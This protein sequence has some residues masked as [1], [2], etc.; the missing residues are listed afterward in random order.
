MSDLVLRYRQSL[1]DQQR[2]ENADFLSSPDPHEDVQSESSEA[3]DTVTPPPSPTLGGKLRSVGGAAL[4]ATKES[5]QSAY[6]HFTKGVTD[7]WKAA[8]QEGIM[9]RAAGIASGQGEMVLGGLTM[10]MTGLGIPAVAAAFEKGMK[11]FTPG[12]SNAEF[13]GPDEATLVRVTLGLPS[14]I[15]DPELRKLVF[16]DRAKLSEEDAAKYDAVWAEIQKPMTYAEG[17]GIG[18]AF[19]LLPTALSGLKQYMNRARIAPEPIPMTFTMKGISEGARVLAREEAFTKTQGPARPF[20]GE[21]P[22]TDPLRVQ[23]AA[24]S[25]TPTATALDLGIIAEDMALYLE[26]VKGGVKGEGKGKGGKKSAVAAPV[27]AKEPAKAPVET[28]AAEKPTTTKPYEEP[29]SPPEYEDFITRL[30][31]AFEEGLK[32]AETVIKKDAATKPELQHLVVSTEKAAVGRKVDKRVGKKVSNDP[33]TPAETERLTSYGM[34][35]EDLSTM[36]PAAAR[37]ILISNKMS[38]RGLVAEVEAEVQRQ[39]SLGEQG[40]ADIGLLARLAVGAAVGCAQGDD[41]EDCLTYGL[42]GMVGAVAAGRLASSLSAKFKTSERMRTLLNSKTKMPGF[43]SPSTVSHT[44]E[45]LNSISKENKDTITKL[46]TRDDTT[47]FAP[48]ELR[49]GKDV[50]MVM[51]ERVSEMLTDITDKNF[52]SRPGELRVALATARTL[53]NK[54]VLGRLWGGATG[55][56]GS[57]RVK[58]ALDEINKLAKEWDASTSE[59]EMAR[60]LKAAGSIKDMSVMARLYYAVPE[61]LTQAYIGGLL[62]PKAIIRNIVGTGIMI[63]ASIINQSL[64]EVIPFLYLKG[65]R[66]TL[67]DGVTGSVALFQGMLDQLKMYNKWDALGRQAEAMGTTHVEVMPKGFASLA[68]ITEEF[69][70]S[71]LADGLRLIDKGISLGA[72]TM[73]RNDGSYKAI[74]GRFQTHLEA[75]EQARV[76]GLTGKAFTD[77]YEHFMTHYDELSPQALLRITEFRNHQTFT[78]PFTSDL[79]RAI[80]MGPTD[81]WLQFTYRIG[82]FPF[83]RTGVRLLEIGAEY[84]PG[85]NAFAAHTWKQVQKGGMERKVQLAQMATGSIV[86]A[87]AAWLAAQGLLTGDLPQHPANI[88]RGY[89]GR[90]HRS[91]WDPVA[92]KYRSYDG[93][94]LVTTIISAGADSAYEINRASETDFSTISMA[95]TLAISSNFTTDAKPYIQSIGKI[96]DA[97]SSGTTDAKW[98]AT[99]QFIRQRFGSAIS[100]SLKE[101][102]GGDVERRVMKPTEY[103]ATHTASAAMLR[104]WRVLVNTLNMHAGLSDRKTIKV[105]RNMFTGKPI[106]RDVWPFNPFTIKDDQMAPWAVEIRRLDGAGLRPLDEWIGKQQSANIGISDKPESP[107]VRLQADELDRWEVLMTQVVKD[108]NGDHLTEAWDKLVQSPAYKVETNDVHKQNQIHLIWNT[109]KMKALGELY[110]ERKPLRDAV[111]KQGMISIWRKMPSE[112]QDAARRM[113][114]RKFG[115]QVAP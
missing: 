52:V 67:G 75:L 57:Y 99:L 1:E 102:L 78:A 2:K 101:V 43:E 45:L 44:Q 89:A 62:G 65:N 115:T 69:G 17:I 22:I 71:T 72:E 42:V 98:E 32:I 21:T 38:E 85:L 46:L 59:L 41:L 80:Q 26:N 61:S 3:E 60:A 110:K 64:A 90:P 63:P 54:N 36:Y 20:E 77:K 73:R 58:I 6:T 27:A 113:I 31:G 16:A 105:I 66:A 28:P 53:A 49:L 79:M 33:L 29:T 95:L 83:V 15:G 91:V 100:P 9:T 96:W 25:S 87:T 14:M 74:F 92:E 13:L 55:G 56:K 104:E 24:R 39:I 108:G 97:V 18:A 40:K 50:E 30:G 48:E 111:E 106:A 19:T 23:R 84:T 51:W 107:G 76:E 103:D 112:I 12:I 7:A 86:G 88:A 68:T 114:E 47:V 70:G 5:A 81:P 8:G 94:G 35:P 37:R 82:I 11:I 34:T 10:L 93:L 4:S 109:F